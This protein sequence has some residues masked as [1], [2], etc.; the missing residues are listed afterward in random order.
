MSCR[1]GVI[2]TET[3]GQLSFDKFRGLKEQSSGFLVLTGR[4]LFQRLP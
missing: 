4:R 2:V 1:T 3:P